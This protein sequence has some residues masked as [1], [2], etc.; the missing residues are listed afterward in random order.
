MPAEHDAD[1]GRLRDHALDEPA[2]NRGVTAE[3]HIIVQAE[4]RIMIRI[5]LA[6]RVYPIR[7][8]HLLPVCKRE[9]KNMHAARL[10]G[11]IIAQ[12][13]LVKRVRGVKIRVG[14]VVEIGRFLVFRRQLVVVARSGQDMHTLWQLGKRRDAVVPF[15]FAKSV[16]DDVSRV[17]GQN[18]V[19]LGLRIRNPLRH[20]AKNVAVRRGIRL[21]VAHPC[22]CECGWFGCRLR[23]WLRCWLR[24]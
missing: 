7:R 18:G 8:L 2:S 13:R 5:L 3:V 1:V 23:R 10:K 11:H 19:V 17:H 24:R 16:V 14:P 22:D 6:N 4:N 21:R 9:H 12:P 15:I 20:L